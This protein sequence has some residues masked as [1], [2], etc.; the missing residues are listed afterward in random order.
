MSDGEGNDVSTCGKFTAVQKKIHWWLMN[1]QQH[2]PRNLEIKRDPRSLIFNLFYARG[3]LVKRLTF[4][5][6]VN[7]WNNLAAPWWFWDVYYFTL[8]ASS[9]LTAVPVLGV[10]PPKG[11]MAL[12]FGNLSFFSLSLP[13]F[14]IF[15][16]HSWFNI[17]KNHLFTFFTVVSN[18]VPFYGW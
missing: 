17:K 18:V 5:N 11:K 10:F 3:H 14:R 4:H 15:S 8:V 1:I 7:S 2:R 16:A 9:K 12:L 13:L 6:K